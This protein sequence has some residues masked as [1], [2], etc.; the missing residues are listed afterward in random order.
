MP[1]S[2]T[3]NIRLIDRELRR[4]EVKMNDVAMSYP[5]N[6]IPDRV[7]DSLAS[8]MDRPELSEEYQYQRHFSG[9]LMKPII[10]THYPESPFSINTANKV[11]FLTLSDE[12]IK[13]RIDELEGK[14]LAFQG[15][16]FKDTKDERVVL[17]REL[18]SN[19]SDIDRM[20]FGSVEMYG[21]VTY[22]NILRDPRVS[23]HCSWYTTVQ[24]HEIAYQINCIAE[25][26]SH[27]D[28]FYRFMRF[29]RQILT[30]R[31]VELRDPEYICAYKFWVSEV[32]E[33]SLSVKPGFVPH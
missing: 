27:D 9:A 11:V 15:K 6:A 22:K 17:Y 21:D 19:D 33:K 4:I 5:L 3:S 2:G 20:R 32:R 10:C 29:L 1:D 23:L 30:Y 13:E 7:Y 14:L 12:I 18:F 28:I 8:A 25:V 24:P 31:F 26:V 16:P